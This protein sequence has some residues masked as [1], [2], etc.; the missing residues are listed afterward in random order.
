MAWWETAV[1]YQVYIRSF[2][3]G[4]GDGLGDLAGL[5][6]RLPYLASLGIQAL[7]INPWYPSP[8][9]DAGYD[10]A[11][12]RDIE[13]SFGTLAEGEELISEAHAL[14]LKVVLD[15]VPN[16]TSSEHAW[17]KAALQGDSQARARYIFRPGK[18]DNG[19]LPPN[20]WE[21]NFGGP[22]WTR[23]LDAEGLE[24]EWY[25]HLFA[26]EQPDLD[27][28]NPEVRFEFEDILRFWF[29]R[30]VDGFRIDVAHGL[31][32]AEGLP[33]FGV[34]PDAPVHS[35]PHPAWDQDDVHEIYRG[36]RKVADSYDPPRIFVAEAWVANNERLANYLRPD[37][38]HTA[39]Q[40]DFLRA[41]WRAKVM[42]EVIDDATDSAAE[43][44]AP[45]TWVL[46]NHDV[47]RHVTRYARSQ[48]PALSE[49]VWVRAQWDKE[50]ADLELGLRRA[51]AAIMLTLALPGTAYLYQG[52][53]FGLAEV[54][55]IP[56]EL[57]Q[58]PMWWQSGYTDPGRDGCRV[59][60][61]WSG[62]QPPFGFSP[63]GATKSPWLPQPKSWATRTQE[64]LEND[65]DSILNLYRAALRLRTE[66]LEG[67]TPPEWIDSPADVLAFRRGDVE[68]WVNTGDVGIQLPDKRVL[69]RSDDG[70]E[71]G[72][73]P[74]DA[75]AWLVD[76]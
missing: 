76:T 45:S 21:S 7:W 71:G 57:R 41:P 31:S 30:D 26:P 42:R 49:S 48:P 56:S 5:R 32:K 55:D 75:A 73:L 50:P 28:T 44:G 9:A 58:D 60:L 15:I 22:A 8:M 63:E 10:V 6:A 69:L 19:E 23:L 17:F 33:D 18:G 3:D 2:R 11:D 16:H 40:F 61:P 70:V 51:R 39:F 14:G 64:A 38:L 4:D 12:Y 66:L 65:P 20:D 46:S 62:D 25:L 59:P 53:E 13:P 74:S 36:W 52:E 35:E 68:C 34:Q 29:D 43:V 1:V 67:M 72:Q 24:G 54:E 27:W 37:E 47:V